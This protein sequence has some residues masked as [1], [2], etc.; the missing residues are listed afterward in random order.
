MFIIVFAYNVFFLAYWL[1]S[2]SSVLFR[3]HYKKLEPLLRLLHIDVK[4]I[5]DYETKLSL[6]K[7]LTLKSNQDEINGDVKDG[8]ISSRSQKGSI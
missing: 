8:S 3:I 4:T 1:F 2:F 6:Q 7:G 5:L